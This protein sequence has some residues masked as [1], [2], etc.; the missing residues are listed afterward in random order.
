MNEIT[1]T[2]SLTDSEAISLAQFLKR[3]S[4]SDYRARAT[5]DDDAYT[6]QDAAAK[7][8]DALVTKGFNPR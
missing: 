8:R 4:Y 7:V 3:C 6:M 2:L 1:I 5:S